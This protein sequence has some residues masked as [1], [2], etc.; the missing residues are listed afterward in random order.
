MKISS[1]L[2]GNLV[3]ASI[4]SSVIP[5]P[6]DT[7]RSWSI[8][9]LSMS[10]VSFLF[11][12]VPERSMYSEPPLVLAYYRA[13]ST[14][15]LSVRL[16]KRGEWY[17]ALTPPNDHLKHATSVLDRS[18]A[19]FVVVSCCFGFAFFCL[20]GESYPSHTMETFKKKRPGYTRTD[21]VPFLCVVPLVGDRKWSPSTKG[22]KR[23]DSEI[24]TRDLKCQNSSFSRQS[25]PLCRTLRENV[26]NILGV[27]ICSVRKLKNTMNILG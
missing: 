18:S 1:F 15:G 24:W 13:S 5:W 10:G 22:W 16:E 11:A 6:H 4:F 23:M 12:G 21:L 26:V 8:S 2:A 19:S 14:N 3:K 9:T 7:G 17:W 20:P 25:P 27:S